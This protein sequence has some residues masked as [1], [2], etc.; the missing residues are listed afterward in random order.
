M[1]KRL[2]EQ[3]DLDPPPVEAVD[4]KLNA[5][6]SIPGGSFTM[7]EGDEAHPVTLAPFTIQEHEVTN[8]EYRRFLSRSQPGLK[9]NYEAAQ[10]LPVVEVTWYDAMAYAAWLGGSLP[11]EAQWE[12]AARGTTGRKYPW[13]EPAP[14]CGR[15]NFKGCEPDGLKPVKTVRD[16]GKTPEGV[17]DLAGNVWEWCR[18]WFAEYPRGEQR[19]PL[20][21]PSGS[22]RVSRGGSF[23]STPE[24]LR[25]AHRHSFG[26][27]DAVDFIGFRVVWPTAGRLD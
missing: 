27:L 17:Y 9:H 12:F 23:H 13:G 8:G 11:T 6:I 5:R 7:G 19:N 16:E 10:D 24:I 1:S 22:A 4:A 25:A 15:A 18:D 3:R 14:E 21:P 2:G 20:G 26:T